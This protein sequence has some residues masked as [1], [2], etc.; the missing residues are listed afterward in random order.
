ML[1]NVYLGP[2]DDGDLAIDVTQIAEFDAL[3]VGP[4][5]EVDPEAAPNNDAKICQH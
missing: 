4:D 2:E 1:A 5:V 3:D